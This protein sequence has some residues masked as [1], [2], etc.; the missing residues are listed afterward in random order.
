MLKN[1]HYKRGYL[2]A[3]EKL[4]LGN[5]KLDLSR[6]N[7][8]YAKGMFSALDRMTMLVNSK[9]LCDALERENRELKTAAAGHLAEKTELIRQIME[10]PFIPEPAQYPSWAKYLAMDENEGWYAYEFNPAKEGRIWSLDYGQIMPIPTPN[11]P[12]RS[13]ET[14]LYRLDNGRYRPSEST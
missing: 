13:W 10:K 4:M 14:S 12:V 11:T 8:H 2:Y 3:V 1:W 6:G 9:K 7:S 5:G